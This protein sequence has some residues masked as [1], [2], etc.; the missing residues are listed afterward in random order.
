MRI[1]SENSP[2]SNM[3]RQDVFDNF[4]AEIRRSRMARFHQ[5]FGQVSRWSDETHTHMVDAV[6]MQIRKRYTIA[7]L[8]L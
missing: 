6:Q 1:P 7:V 8:L 5:I 2:P 4:S 3:P